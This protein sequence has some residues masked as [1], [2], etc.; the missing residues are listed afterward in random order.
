MKDAANRRA[1]KE[2]ETATA[3][4][5]FPMYLG[6]MG[7]YLGVAYGLFELVSA[8]AQSKGAAVETAAMFGSEDVYVF[9][10]GVVVAMLTSLFGL[11]FTTFNN[12]YAS[13]TLDSLESKKD[14]FFNF[15]QTK[16]L[17]AMP[18]TLAQALKHELQK[19]IGTLGKTIGALDTTVSSLNIEL[20]STFEDLTTQFGDKLWG[21]IQAMQEV[22][23]TL[24]TSASAYTEAMKK[25]DEILAKMNNPAFTKV[26]D[27][28]AN[29]VDRCEA[30]SETVDAVDLTMESI[31]TRQENTIEMQNILLNSQDVMLKSQK[32]VCDRLVSAEQKFNE[33][34]VRLHEELSNVTLEA[35]QRLNILM[36]EPS[37]FFDYVKA[38]LEQ[39]AKIEAFVE[40][41]TSQEFATQAD[42]T[43]YINAQIQEIEKAGEAVKNYLAA[44]KSGLETYLDQRKDEIKGSASEFVSSWNRLFNEMVA[45]GAE[46]PL[47]Y[48]K[49]LDGLESRLTNIQRSLDSAKVDERLITELKDIENILK[50]LKSVGFKTNVTRQRLHMRGKASLK[51]SLVAIKNKL[52]L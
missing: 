27:K 42:K 31:R 14:S 49:Q 24:T 38:T 8:M 5:A 26:L 23:T 3:N 44:T 1:E 4:T 2:Y 45:N 33:N 34:T 22:V 13:K 35:Q 7:T 46:N 50:N 11:I 18:S 29:T 17:P 12:N 15:L 25:Q 40:S 28:I 9:I 6:L 48:L 21:S 51:E 43:K 37:K 20:K 16:I 10:G 19:S 36:A 32:E 52:I 30:I 39:F 41:V 47:A